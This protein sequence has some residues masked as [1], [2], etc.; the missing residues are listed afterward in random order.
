MYYEDM[1]YKIVIIG[2]SGVGKSS[3]LSRIIKN[4]FN[5]D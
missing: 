4:E 5:I 2:D 3:I 1:V